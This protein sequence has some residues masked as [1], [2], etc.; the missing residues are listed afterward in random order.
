M[1]LDTRSLLFASALGGSRAP[2]PHQ[3]RLAASRHA[4]PVS[5]APPPA[6]PPPAFLP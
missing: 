4:P 2:V 5:V 1:P 3:H 6:S